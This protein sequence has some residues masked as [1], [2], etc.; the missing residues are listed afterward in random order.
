MKGYNI[1]ILFISIF[2][3]S[4]NSSKSDKFNFKEEF[5]LIGRGM[6]IEDSAYLRYP[7]RI[8]LVEDSIIYLLD[9][10]GP[11]HYVHSF[12]YPNL[13]YKASFASRGSGP[14]DFLSVEN[15]R[16]N[17]LKDMILLDSNKETLSIVNTTNDSVIHTKLPKDLIRCLDFTIINDS[18][19]AIPDYTGKYRVQIID[20]NGSIKK[21][22]FR[23]PSKERG[24]E[25]ISNIVLAQAW[26]SFIDYNPVNGVLAMATQLGQV[27]EIY[28]LNTDK[29]V[30]IL[31]GRYGEPKFA[32][33]GLYA[34]PNGIM[35]YSDI[36]VGENKIYAIFWGYT[37]RDMQKNPYD[38]MDGGNILQVFS[39]EGVP[40]KQ[41]KLD[42]NITGFHIDE[43]NK[44]LIGLDVNN[45]QQLIEY[46]L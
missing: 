36:H 27:I 15:I 5:L 29:E 32:S 43:K 17:S 40:L 16:F 28:D 24:N 6:S 1:I 22:L 45:E 35:G 41:Y 10:H 42:R 38:R 21:Q 3:L 39:I 31:Y 13:T 2:T 34:I 7:F 4:C 23:I 37:F 8:R 11:N 14:D 33:Q 19:F 9:L 12:S 20:N 30:S 18:T 46:N 25:N 26:R 44:K